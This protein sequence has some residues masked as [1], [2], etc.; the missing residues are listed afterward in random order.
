M[1][2]QRANVSAA[3]TTLEMPTTEM[4]EPRDGVADYR[5]SVSPPQRESVAASQIVQIGTNRTNPPIG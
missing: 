4:R 5:P 3:Q 1:E 2:A